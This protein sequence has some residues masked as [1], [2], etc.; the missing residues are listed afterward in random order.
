MLVSPQVSPNSPVIHRHCAR[1]TQPQGAKIEAHIRQVM[2]HKKR[3]T[4][5]IQKA[6]SMSRL[7]TLKESCQLLG[8]SRSSIY[9]LIAQGEFDVVYVLSSPRITQNSI[10]SYITR[11]LVTKAVSK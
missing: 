4:Y 11:H 2:Q 10:D 6:H 9:R 1:F 3:D 7:F 8:I 5:E